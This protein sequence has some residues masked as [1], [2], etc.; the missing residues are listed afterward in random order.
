VL[1]RYCVS[2]G[3]LCRRRMLLWFAYKPISVCQHQRRRERQLKRNETTNYS[4]DA[5]S[6]A[7]RRPAAWVPTEIIRR[8][9]LTG[10]ACTPFQVAS[11]YV[12]LQQSS[13]SLSTAQNV[14]QE[15][16]LSLTTRVASRGFS[17]QR[18]LFLYLVIT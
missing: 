14:V 13:S 15:V 6:P 1:T 7:G 9:S 12:S 11:L 17:I 16:W 5:R 18:S 4:F 10:D 8:L 2:T 3:V